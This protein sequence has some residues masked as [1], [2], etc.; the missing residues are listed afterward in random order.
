MSAVTPHSRVGWLGGLLL[1]LLFCAERSLAADLQTDK[2]RFSVR[3]QAIF[4]VSA[5]FKNLGAFPQQS[6]PGPATNGVDHFYDDGYN[7]VDAS[8]NVDGLTSFW[9]YE[10]PGQVGS[11]T[12]AMH[13]AS[14]TGDINL[15]VEG[16]VPQWGLEFVYDRELGSSGSYWWAVELGVGWL[17]LS[18]H[19]DATFNSEVTLT[20]DTY[21]LN[22]VTPP[23]APYSG[24]YSGQGPLLGDLP[25]RVVT[26]L[27]RAAVTSGHYRLDA[28]MY[29]FRLGLLYESPFNDWLGL[30]FGGGGL[31][32]F[33]DAEMSYSE[34]TAYGAITSNRSGASSE[35]GFIGGAY[36]NA[37]L[38]FHFS[39]RIVATVGA[40]YNYLSDF[41]QNTDGKEASIDFK[42]S[43]SVMAGLGVK[44]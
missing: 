10:N 27:P 11:D 35:S 14:G 2:N 17:D 5:T 18:F 9:G 15:K 7:R 30:Q 8:G 20:T 6:N 23:L 13:S 29:T 40:Q 33:V 22:G 31:A 3:G 12:I 21:A 19:D 38:A 39:E 25:S 26:S 1:L 16:D 36:A 37:G 44:F 32:A 41:N 43:I 24:P 4:G 42:N 28:N 34:Q